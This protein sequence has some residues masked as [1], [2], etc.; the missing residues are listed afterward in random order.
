MRSM[1]QSYTDFP[2]SDRFKP[3]ICQM[4]RIEGFPGYLHLANIFQ[5]ESRLVNVMVPPKGTFSFTMTYAKTASSVVVFDRREKDFIIILYTF[6]TRMFTKIRESLNVAL[7]IYNV[8]CAKKGWRGEVRPEFRPWRSMWRDEEW[9]NTHLNVWM[10]D[11]FPLNRPIPSV[12][13][14]VTLT[15]TDGK[16]THIRFGVPGIG[17]DGVSP[18]TGPLEPLKPPEGA[19]P[20]TCAGCVSAGLEDP[21]SWRVKPCEGGVETRGG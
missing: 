3:G 16:R 21:C 6:A 5:D 18:Y 7:D 10:G 11:L 19:I 8:E 13:F 20:F 9:C 15:Q 1:R 17:V 12:P 14:P 4:F 2:N